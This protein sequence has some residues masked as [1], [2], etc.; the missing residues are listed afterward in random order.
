MEE[1]KWASMKRPT[2][3]ARCRLVNRSRRMEVV[4]KGTKVYFIVTIIRHSA[5][6]PCADYRDTNAEIN[7]VSAM[8]DVRLSPHV[9]TWFIFVWIILGDGSETA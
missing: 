4:N 9:Q 8:R 3:F 5:L 2:L 6:V 7:T 1:L